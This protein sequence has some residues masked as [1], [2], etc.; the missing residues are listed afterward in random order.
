[1]KKKKKKRGKGKVPLGSL[2]AEP[3]TSVTSFSKPLGARLW[4][5]AAELHSLSVTY[6]WCGSALTNTTDNLP[7]KTFACFCTIHHTQPY[8]TLS[9]NGFHK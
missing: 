4:H 1:M 5:Y 8:K 6:P 3:V 9:P 7:S 2:L